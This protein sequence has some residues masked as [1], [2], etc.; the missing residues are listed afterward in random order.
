MI[1]I[2]VMTYNSN[3]CTGGD[4][5][6]RPERLAQVIA[7]SAPDI[8]ALQDISGSQL[9]QLAEEL[10]M[11]CWGGQEAGDVGLLSYYPLTAVQAFDLGD[12]GRCQRADFEHKGQRL[13]LFNVRLTSESAARQRQIGSLLGAD[14][15]SNRS[16]ACPVLI[17]GDFAD[18]WWGAGNFSMALMLQRAP[19]PW[20]GGTYPA[21]LP[22]FGR[23]R[24]YGLND[25]KFL[26]V[27]IVRTTLARKASQHLPVVYT[28]RVTDPRI[29]LR[30]RQPLKA[31]RMEIAHG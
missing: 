26:D 18:Y 13:H 17:C 8:V 27:N 28:I 22:L 30:Q 24:A 19:R 7:A 12:G 15:L 4:G 21:Q 6:C 1:S 16:L 11:R 3:G 29:S 10:G 23:D 14:L 31:R 25:L 20:W 5:L 2:R 9:Q